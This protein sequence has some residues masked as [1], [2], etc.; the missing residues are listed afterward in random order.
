MSVPY[1]IPHVSSSNLTDPPG[2]AEKTA[3]F[4]D[5]LGSISVLGNFADVDCRLFSHVSNFE[6][7]AKC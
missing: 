4:V 5:L 7:V 1:R 3:N 6:T 2:L